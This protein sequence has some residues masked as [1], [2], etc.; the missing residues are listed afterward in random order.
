METGF[1]VEVR[2]MEKVN[3]KKESL[4]VRKFKL[5]GGPE[6][7]KGL[8]KDKGQAHERGDEQGGGAKE[9]R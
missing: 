2:L 6:N 1:S 4:N 5:A 8:R 3:R 7:A 9:S